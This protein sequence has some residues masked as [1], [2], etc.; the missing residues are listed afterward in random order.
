MENH[1]NY[2]DSPR[3][4]KDIKNKTFI[5]KDTHRIFQ[6]DLQVVYLSC[7]ERQQF[8]SKLLECQNKAESHLV[9][10]TG[11][12]EA[13]SWKITLEG[14]IRRY[15]RDIKVLNK[16]LINIKNHKQPLPFKFDLFEGEQV[17]TV[18]VKG[19]SC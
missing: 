4:V 6:E 8:Y 16:I 9:T 19:C 3:L 13:H 17:V 18:S 11:L 10:S 7:I 2:V 15:E 14:Q 1:R 5:K 12:K